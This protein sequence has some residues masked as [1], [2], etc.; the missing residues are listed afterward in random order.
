MSSNMQRQA[1]P[2]SWFENCIVGTGLERQ[3]ALDSGVLA[4]AEHEGKIIY[5][6]IDKILL[7]NNGDTLSIPSVIYQ[8]SNKNTCMHKRTQVARGYNSEDAVLINEHLVYEDIYTSFHIR[9]YEIQTHVTSHG[10]E[11][12]TNEI[13]HLDKEGIVMLVLG[14]DG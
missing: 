12:I 6:D 3:V 9:K 1:V 14:G 11:R 2:L 10:L 7:S 5:T 13:P 8:R 4:I